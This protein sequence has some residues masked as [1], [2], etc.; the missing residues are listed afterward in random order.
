MT[1]NH[2]DPDKPLLVFNNSTERLPG[3]RNHRQ[4][5]R[6]ESASSSWS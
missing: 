5:W 4:R 2:R 6:S 3:G 1:S